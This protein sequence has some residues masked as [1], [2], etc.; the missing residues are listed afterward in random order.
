MLNTQHN[1]TTTIETSQ[2]KQ[3]MR[4]HAINQQHNNMNT[5]PSS[6]S[7]HQQIGMAKQA[8]KVFVSDPANQPTRNH[9]GTKFPG[10]VTLEHFMLWA[11]LRGKSPA[12]CS[13]DVKGERYVQALAYLTRLFAGQDQR[14]REALNALLLRAFGGHIT[15]DDAVKNWLSLQ[16]KA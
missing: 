3:T 2:G 9:Y 8:F 7:R 16:H 15:A 10:K 4:Q 11:V 14:S 5:A 13:H 1:Q 12:C 6:T